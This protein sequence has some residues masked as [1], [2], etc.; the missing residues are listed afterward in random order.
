MLTTSEMQNAPRASPEG[1]VLWSK[2][3]EK[4][5]YPHPRREKN[6]RT[7]GRHAHTGSGKTQE[8]EPVFWVVCRFSLRIFFARTHMEFLPALPMGE[9][10]PAPAPPGVCVYGIGPV[11]ASGLQDWTGHAPGHT[12]ASILAFLLGKRPP[13]EGCRPAIFATDLCLQQFAT[14]PWTP[15]SGRGRGHFFWSIESSLTINELSC[16][17]AVHF[18]FVLA[19]VP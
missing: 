11:L 10:L 1:T 5:V 19:Y 13:V 8:K 7:S 12:P 6:N 14:D 3:K 15:G 4:Q 2:L 18:L 16:F 17:C 9:A